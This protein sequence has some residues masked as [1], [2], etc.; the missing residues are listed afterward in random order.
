MPAESIITYAI[1]L[2]LSSLTAGRAGTRIKALN[3]FKLE[4]EAELREREREEAPRCKGQ[5]GEGKSKMT[6]TKNQ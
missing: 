4:R 1:C 6:K 3:A 2:S 5:L